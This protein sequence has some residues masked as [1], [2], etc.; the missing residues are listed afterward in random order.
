[1]GE[2]DTGFAER[3]RPSAEAAAFRWPVILGGII[4]GFSFFCIVV[5]AGTAPLGVTFSVLA[6]VFLAI[7]TR[8]GIRQQPLNMFF[9]IAYALAIVLFAVWA[10]WQ[11]GLPEF[12]EVG[13]V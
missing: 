8:K 1:M 9:L 7:W 5:E 2:T 6:T 13:F 3:G 12:S 11:G 4:H 10:I